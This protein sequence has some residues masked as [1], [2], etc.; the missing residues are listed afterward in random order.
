M[1]GKLA[2]FYWP[3]MLFAMLLREISAMSQLLFLGWWARQYT[4]YPSSEINAFAYLGFYVAL[5]VIVCLRYS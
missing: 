1:C 5:L 2:A 4:I 3:T